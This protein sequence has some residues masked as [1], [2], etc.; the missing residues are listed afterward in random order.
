MLALLRK[1]TTN[2]VVFWVVK[3]LVAF[4]R[5]AAATFFLVLQGVV[6]YYLNIL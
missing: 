4:V 3:T 6:Q 5:Y 1:F 2:I